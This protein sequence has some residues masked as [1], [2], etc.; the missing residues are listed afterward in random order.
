MESTSLGIIANVFIIDFGL[1]CRAA[2]NDQQFGGFGI[3]NRLESQ[4]TVRPKCLFDLQTITDAITS[5]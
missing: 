2:G 5:L 1:F 3:D 4:R